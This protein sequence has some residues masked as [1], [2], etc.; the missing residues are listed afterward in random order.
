MEDFP[1]E[2][3]PG[4]IRWRSR[5]NS[6]GPGITEVPLLQH[7]ALVMDQIEGENEWNK[8]RIEA[9]MQNIVFRMAS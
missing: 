8:K 5:S 1:E 7:R 9:L 4:Q 6:R 3:C 2:M